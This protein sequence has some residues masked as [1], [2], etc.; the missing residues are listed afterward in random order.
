MVTQSVTQLEENLRTEVTPDIRQPKKLTEDPKRFFRFSLIG[1]IS[2]VLISLGVSWWWH[3]SSIQETEDA[4]IT[5]H[6]HQLSAK[7]SGTVLKVAVEDNQHVS[8]G[9]LLVK[10]DPRDFQ[11][12]ADSAKAA[13]SK[14][15]K[16]A[17]E[18]QSNI[19]YSSRTAE[20][21]HLEA[22]YGIASA[23]AQINKARLSLAEAK[24]GVDM[25]AAQVQ[26]REAELTRAV[27]DFHRYQALVQDRAVTVQ[28]FETARQNK[29]VAEANLRAAQE[30]FNQAKIRVGEFQQALADAQAILVRVDGS[31]QTAA[32]ASAQTET[33]KLTVSV[34]QSA[35][36]QAESQYE[37]SLL[38]LSY[39]NVVAPVAGTVG[40]K[41]VE[42]G[43]QTERGQ[44]L[45]S[46]V[47]DEKWVVANF[48]ETQLEKM[49]VGQKVDIRIDAF[50]NKHFEG[51]VDSIAP[52][53][54]AQFAL[55]PPDN[56][57]GNFTKVVQR[58]P[59]KIVFDPDCIKGY[60]KLLTPGMSVIPE[61]HVLR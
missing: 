34:Q 17:L 3:A 43:Q 36:K 49:R 4:F 58:V 22:S 57:T 54:G 14:A 56:A 53:S 47:S 48:K 29:Q 60:E 27:A 5:G 11:I 20:A 15:E 44:A 41:T 8:Q 28:S 37:N 16:Q 50:P 12:S 61:V 30:N 33:S 39:T 2:L 18:A 10:I 40:H 35:A 21:R 13:A 55:L 42:V 23:N 24:A 19:V 52:A 9:Q 7:V 59:V 31:V 32:A 6:I 46:I 1:L 26:Q 45:M 25:A 38:Q 51:T